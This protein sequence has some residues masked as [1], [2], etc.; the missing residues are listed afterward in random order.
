[1]VGLMLPT[2]N[3]MPHLPLAFFY[4]YICMGNES[5]KKLLHWLPTNKLTKDWVLS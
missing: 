1:M 5:A 3:K 4:V 2:Q